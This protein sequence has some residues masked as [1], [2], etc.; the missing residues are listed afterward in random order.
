[1]KPAQ[2]RTHIGWRRR[3]SAA[4]PPATRRRARR[5][6]A[7]RE[8]CARCLLLLNDVHD[9]RPGGRAEPLPA[10]IRREERPSVLHE[11]RPELLE[12]L[13]VQHARR[14]AVVEQQYGKRP[15]ASG[16]YSTPLSCT[17]PFENDTSCAARARLAPRMRSCQR[18]ASLSDARRKQHRT[19]CQRREVSRALDHASIS[20][21]F[22]PARLRAPAA[23]RSRQHVHEEHEREHYA[24]VGLELQRREHPRDHADG[25]RDAG[26]DDAGPRHAQRAL[27]RVVHGKPSFRQICMRLNR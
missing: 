21:A 1:M 14:A 4:P 6:P 3:Q 7:A 24:N 19:S 26:E 27:V 9:V 12:R 10:P 5:E 18:S 15:G 16:L 17:L 11:Q 8:R 25:E 22:S 20:F 2:T 13:P 23:A